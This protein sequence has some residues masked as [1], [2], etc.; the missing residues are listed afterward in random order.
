LSH[1]FALGYTP[2]RGKPDSSAVEIHAD[3][4]ALRTEHG[5][6][7]IVGLEGDRDGAVRPLAGNAN[8]MHPNTA[9][10]A[11]VRSL[12][13]GDHALSCAIFASPVDDLAESHPA[14]PTIANVLIARIASASMP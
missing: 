8:L 11:L 10:P 6:S 5:C 12:E 9:V 2:L 1:G 13:I 14:V 3:F 7:A 4:A